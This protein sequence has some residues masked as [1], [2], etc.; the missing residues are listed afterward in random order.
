MHEMEYREPL[1]I[2]ILSPYC[3][4]HKEL[5]LTYH[6]YASSQF[7]TRALSGLKIRINRDPYRLIKI[8][9][10]DDRMTQELLMARNHDRESLLANLQLA[11]EAL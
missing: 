11:K 10:E 1:L 3:V 7:F 2:Q 4:A 8:V 9:V 6:A 5:I